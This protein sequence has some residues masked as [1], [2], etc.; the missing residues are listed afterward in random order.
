VHLG[1]DDIGEVVELQR[2]RVRDDGDLRTG[3]QPRRRDVI[4]R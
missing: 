2:A 3:E 1:G 4:V